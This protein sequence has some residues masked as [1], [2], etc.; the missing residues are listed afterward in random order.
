MN[1]RP[2]AVSIAMFGMTLGAVLVYLG[3]AWFT[4]ARARL[5]LALSSLLF[6]VSA[7]WSIDIH[8]R[9]AIDPALISYAVRLA[10]ATNVEVGDLA[11]LRLALTRLFEHFVGR[12]VQ[13]LA[14]SSSRKS[15][16]C[17][18]ARCRICR[19]PG[20]VIVLPRS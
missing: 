15:A 16:N 13:R 7:A 4:P 1:S 3:S 20:A 6:G 11:S 18:R 17:S 10:K 2:V 9:L 14:I 19:T 12:V 5:N 8:L